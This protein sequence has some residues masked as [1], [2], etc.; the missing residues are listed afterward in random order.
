MIPKLLEAYCYT[1]TKLKCSRMSSNFLI[2]DRDPAMIY[3]KD[4]WDFSGSIILEFDGTTA[5]TG[6]AGANVEF[7][8]QGMS[9]C[10]VGLCQ[11]LSDTL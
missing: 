5:S 4:E 8:F 10:M 2:D 11:W 3:S 9:S 1:C 6:T 7:T